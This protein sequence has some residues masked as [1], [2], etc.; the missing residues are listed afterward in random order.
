MRTGNVLDQSDDNIFVSIGP[1]YVMD[2][3]GMGQKAIR[4]DGFT[5]IK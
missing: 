2:C 3:Y 4:Y 1:Q 5:Q